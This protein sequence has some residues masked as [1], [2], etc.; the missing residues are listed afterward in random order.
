MA[1]LAQQ[2]DHRNEHRIRVRWHAEAFIEGQG[3]FRGFI[4][5][6]S[7]T[8]TGIFL[9]QNVRMVDSFKLRI[10]M[11]PLNKSSVLHTM[12]VSAK[13][14]Y[15]TLDSYESLFHTGVRF[16]Q[17]CLPSDQ[18]YLQMRIATLT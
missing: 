18:T 2:Q 7:M 17:F 3:V 14:L 11:P 16:I 5:E 4:K 15:T 13:V 12:D 6:I 8:G 9:H 1:R 10:Y